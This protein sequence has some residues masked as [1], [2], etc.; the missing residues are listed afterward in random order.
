MMQLNIFAVF[1]CCCLR[2]WMQ[3]N[4]ARQKKCVELHPKAVSLP[5]FFTLHFLPVFLSFLCWCHRRPAAQAHTFSHTHSKRSKN[6]NGARSMMIADKLRKSVYTRARARS[7]TKVWMNK[8]KRAFSSK[9]LQ[10]AKICL[11]VQVF[12]FSIVSRQTWN[13]IW[14]D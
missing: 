5:C 14:G 9:E 7:Y 3:K 6:V 1:C 13:E 10:S 11:S 8:W 4:S 12:Y 2:R